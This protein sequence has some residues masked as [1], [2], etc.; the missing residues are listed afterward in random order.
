MAASARVVNP[1]Y[2][3]E[4]GYLDVAAQKMIPA[5]PSK[6]SNIAVAVE[7]LE[8]DTKS[9]RKTVR[10]LTY[11]VAFSILLSLIA[12]GLAVASMSNTADSTPNEDLL[13]P[14]DDVKLLRASLEHQHTELKAQNDTLNARL[15]QQQTELK[16]QNDTVKALRTSLEQQQMELKTLG[17]PKQDCCQ[18]N[19]SFN[20]SHMEEKLADIVTKTKSQIQ[21]INSSIEGLTSK[22]STIAKTTCQAQEENRLEAQVI[23]MEA[24]QDIEPFIAANNKRYIAVAGKPKDNIYRL[25]DKGKLQ[26]E[27]ILNNTSHLARDIEH[28]RID[29]ID[30]LAVGSYFHSTETWVTESVIYTLNTFQN[31]ELKEFQRIETSGIY[32]FE[33]FQIDGVHHLMAINYMNSTTVNELYPG[34]SV[35]Y[36][37]DPLQQQFVEYQQITTA[38]SHAAHFFTFNGS[39]F[40]FTANYHIQGSYKVN[41]T[42]YIFEGGVMLPQQQIPT[43]GAT[44]V[45]SFVINGQLYLFLSNYYDGETYNVSSWIYKM[46]NQK[47]HEVI[48]VPT[49]GAFDMEHFNFH[50]RDYIIVANRKGKSVIYEWDNENLIE[51]RRF[52]TQTA[53]DVAY[54][55]FNGF[56]Y[57]AFANERKF[58]GGSANSMVYR[59]PERSICGE[60]GF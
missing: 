13:M 28:F 25:D 49:N 55:E 2:D 9:L 20:H 27:F 16:A 23:P 45:N 47:L 1:M 42:L 37:F 34:K 32:Q 57:L 54:W 8:A 39:H 38:A 56:A 31:M 51:K 17:A 12:T 21:L 19:S 15:E 53:V 52:D 14:N 41:S 35:I 3:D 46:E 6:I 5:E 59:L 30:F 48:S 7:D 26:L 4:N 22:T 36:R 44:N 40:L 33:Y 43:Q 10:Y 50:G 24:V 18:A 58:S 60:N 11:G 29:S